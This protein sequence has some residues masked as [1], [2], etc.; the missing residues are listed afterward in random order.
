MLRLQ[1]P[2]LAAVP[3]RLLVAH[4]AHRSSRYSRLSEKNHA[5]PELHARP[6]ERTKPLGTSSSLA[7]NPSES[8]TGLY[9]S[10]LASSHS[11][12]LKLAPP[13][14]PLAIY[15][16]EVLRSNHTTS[17]SSH[18]EHHASLF[19]TPTMHRLRRIRHEQE[20]SVG[21]P[22]GIIPSTNNRRIKKDP[23]DSALTW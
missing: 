6:I 17:S 9:N 12:D 1:P 8:A 4:G 18:T 5:T 2:T 10:L 23:R 11:S 13:P 7:L 19:E 22:T 20:S 21:L 14:A 3:P 15:S 16:C